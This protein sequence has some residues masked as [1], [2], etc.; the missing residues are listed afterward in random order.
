MRRG[1][2][3]AVLI[4]WALLPSAARAQTTLSYGEA[5]QGAL[6]AAQPEARY[7]FGGRAG[8]AVLIA[9]DS[10]DSESLD[11]LV[12]LLDGEQRQV[13]AFGR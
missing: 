5:V 6:S 1:L 11:P 13:L 4:A 12:M 9:V 10:A 2:I 8:D 3:A 7:R